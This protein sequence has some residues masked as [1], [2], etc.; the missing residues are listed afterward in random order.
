MQNVLTNTSMVIVVATLAILIFVVA[1]VLMIV[2]SSRRIIQEQQTKIDA[3]QKSEE[4]YKALFD[5]SLAGMMKF[6]YR[7]WIV[8]DANQALLEMF[9]VHS[10]YEFQRIMTELPADKL[11][12][13][14]RTLE[15]S[16]IIDGLELTRVVPSGITRRYF[17]SA[18][19]ESTGTLAHAVVVLMTAEKKI[20]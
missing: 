9:T 18:R 8:L 17:F 19:K 1:Y 13:I 7:T 6:D 15:H 16:G 2:T 20:G 12:Q 14:E 3:I 10:V 5:N 4:R 11:R